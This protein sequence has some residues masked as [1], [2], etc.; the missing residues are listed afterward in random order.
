MLIS[1]NIPLP[2]RLLQ[3]HFNTHQG[4]PEFMACQR[5]PAVLTTNLPLIDDWLQAQNCFW[6]TGEDIRHPTIE[7][8]ILLDDSNKLVTS[9]IEL[10]EREQN[11]QISYKRQLFTFSREL[12]SLRES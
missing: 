1:P 4:W 10:T 7:L 8:M 11:P 9:R 6:V 12:E 5:L 2:A 3:V